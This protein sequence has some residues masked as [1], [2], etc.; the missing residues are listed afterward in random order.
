[1]QFLKQFNGLPG[2]NLGDVRCGGGLFHGRDYRIRAP[3]RALEKSFARVST[4]LG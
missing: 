1:M 3:R 2:A 4:E